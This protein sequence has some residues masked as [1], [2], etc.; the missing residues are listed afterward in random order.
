MRV[1]NHLCV[2]VPTIRVP[3]NSTRWWYEMPGM[4]LY[5]YCWRDW[6]RWIVRVGPW[7]AMARHLLLLCLLLLLLLLLGWLLHVIHNSIVLFCW[8]ESRQR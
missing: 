1:R 2:V 4:V 6:P 7:M 3:L 5:R 8:D